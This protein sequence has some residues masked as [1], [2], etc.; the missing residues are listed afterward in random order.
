[1]VATYQPF[2]SRAVV[3]LTAYNF[4]DVR[5]REMQLTTTWGKLKRL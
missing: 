2:L 1:M 4:L 5:L 3:S